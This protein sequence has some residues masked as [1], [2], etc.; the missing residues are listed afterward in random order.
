MKSQ[1]IK[2]VESGRILELI[3]VDG[4]GNISQRK[5]KVLDVNAESFCAYCYTRQ[6]RRT[7]KLDNI[8]SIGHERRIRRGA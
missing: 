1:L 3:Y 6:Q 5:I 8:L 7:F 2:A 4:K